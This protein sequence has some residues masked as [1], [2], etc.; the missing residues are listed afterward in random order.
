MEKE[1][2]PKLWNGHRKPV[3]AAADHPPVGLSLIFK[4]VMN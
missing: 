2:I 3:P 1:R 4:N